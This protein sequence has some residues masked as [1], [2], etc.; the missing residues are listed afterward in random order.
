MD[1]S[2]LFGFWRGELYHLGVPFVNRKK[3]DMKIAL[4]LGLLCVIMA[5]M[6]AFPR[7]T[8][9]ADNPAPTGSITV[10]G[11]A[12]V[13]VVPDE[14]IIILGVETSDKDLLTA[15]AQNDERIKNLIALAK[16]YNIAPG[17]IQT[18]Y[19][20]IEPR[21]QDS[22]QQRE[23]IGY[24]VRKT[25]VFTLKDLSK[26][27]DLFTGALQAGAN[28]VQGIDF[29]TTELRKHRDEA[30]DLAIK[31]AQE[32]A[33][34]LAQALGQKPL[35]PTSINE[36]GYYW[37]SSYGSWWGSR[38]GPAQSQNISQSSGGGAP[39][40]DDS[41]IALGQISVTAMVSVTFDLVPAN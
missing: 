41:T 2:G 23:F 9:L 29:R 14:V 4:K 28:Y 12:E 10:S 13:K 25:I 31:A 21:Y 32:K 30:R 35:R 36:N 38:Y 39:A 40:S 7:P 18:D 11:S 15:K 20:G 33:T 6:L 27:E 34:A 8:V 5:G 17:D 16:S 24:F 26:F 3:G 22:Y 37:G 19:I 1:E